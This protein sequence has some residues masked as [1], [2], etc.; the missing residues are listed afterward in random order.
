MSAQTSE[1]SPGRPAKWPVQA[2]LLVTKQED[3]RWLRLN[4]PQRRNA[5]NPELVAALDAAIA[6]ACADPSTRIVII[7]GAGPS[8]CTGADLRHLQ[9][10]AADGN[11][12]RAFL[13]AVSRCFT[14]L[15]C[16]P[17]PVVAAVHG[18][19]VAGGLELALACDVVVAVDGTLIGDGHVRN[20]LLPAGGASVRLPRKMGE[21]LA[22]W[23]LLTGQL[24]PAEAFIPSG[25]V[26]ATAPAQ[27]F[28]DL[29]AN[30]AAALRSAQQAAQ[31][32]IKQLLAEEATSRT[33]ALASELDTFAGHWTGNDI[34]AQLKAF[35]AR[36]T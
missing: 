35:F 8:F 14:S 5:L 16:C 4:R 20:G 1:W 27:Q 17:K 34:A 13:S 30:V 10:I 31:A 26:H 28:N 24:L 6:D 19:V 2:P 32:R 11:D 21:P 12:P 7:T 29:I 22:R 23:L 15:E 9:A 33:A 18:H 36:D 25:F 3:I